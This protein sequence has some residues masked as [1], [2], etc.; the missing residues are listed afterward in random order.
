M[1]E[2]MVDYV[3]SDNPKAQKVRATIRNYLPETTC[4]LTTW[5]INGEIL[6]PRSS[7]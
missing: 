4:P 1:L 5:N 6:D 2:K 7:S 3:Y